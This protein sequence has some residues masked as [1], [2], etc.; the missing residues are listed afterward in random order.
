MSSP[1]VPL[2]SVG[3]AL[4]LS[5][6]STAVRQLTHGMQQ[7]AIT[8][9]VCSDLAT[10]SRIIN[11]RKFEV[12]VV[13]LALGEQVADVL[14]RIRFSPANQKSVTFALVES[15]ARAEPPVQP[16]FIMQKP[17]TDGLVGSTLKAALGLII[18]DYRR[19]FRC[20][21]TVPLVLRMPG[22]LPVSCQ[23]MNVS[24]GG[25]AVHTPVAFKPG[26]VV[27]AKFTLPD[28][29]TEFDIDCEVS[30]FDNQ[31]RAG[32]EFLSV[33]PEQK[34]ILQLWLSHRIEQGLPEHVARMFQKSS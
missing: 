19:Y 23:T 25:V 7:F 28:E 21:A 13:D 2:P 5:N 10:A 18:R 4:L 12:I 3:R 16:N 27:K 20:P 30:W 15:N 29:L 1:S 24:E 26:A 14:E 8:A 33:S 9:E 22:E 32:L 17:L 34:L 31:G 11:T 6:D